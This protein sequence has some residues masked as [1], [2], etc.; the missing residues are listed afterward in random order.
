MSVTILAF[1]S[2]MKATSVTRV[3][4]TDQSAERRAQALG[5]RGI[6]FVLSRTFANLIALHSFFSD[7]HD[8]FPTREGRF[9]L[10]MNV[11]SGSLGV[12]RQTRRPIIHGTTARSLKGKRTKNRLLRIHGIATSRNFTI[13]FKPS[14]CPVRV[15]T[16]SSFAGSI[17][18]MQG[19]LSSAI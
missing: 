11:H 17:E 15:V 4:V 5:T 2:R 10:V 9:C 13:C 6:L 3:P 19:T 1:R 14:A 18:M 8:S 16:M 12:R 7:A